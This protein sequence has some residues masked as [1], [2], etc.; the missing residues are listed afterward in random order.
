MSATI[1][2]SHLDLIN[3][4]YLHVVIT[5]MPDGQPQASLVAGE[6]IVLVKVIQHQGEWKLR[7]GIESQR[8]LYPVPQ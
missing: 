4:P 6:N 8:P 3:G 2:E 5:V 7:L 1:P